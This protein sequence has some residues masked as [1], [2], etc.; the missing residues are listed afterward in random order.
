MIIIIENINTSLTDD[1]CYPYSINKKKNKKKNNNGIT[2]PK[3][4]WAHK[5]F[6]SQFI[7][8]A[9]VQFAWKTNKNTVH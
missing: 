2:I 9:R 4:F 3:L 8:I 6:R 7:S 5:E 1:E